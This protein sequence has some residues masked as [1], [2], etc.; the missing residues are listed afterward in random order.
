MDKS[1]L[2]G[3]QKFG[4]GAIIA[5]IALC[6]VMAC[7]AASLFSFNPLA[8]DDDGDD[9]EVVSV[10]TEED[11]VSDTDYQLGNV[12]AAAAIDRN[13]C[14]TSLTNNFNRTEDVYVV[15]EDSEIEAGTDIFVR[16][17]EGDQAVEDTDEITAD[18]DYNNVC[19]NFVFEPEQAFDP[20]TYEAEVYVNGI[21]VENVQFNIQ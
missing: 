11:I 15:I 13:G 14:A 18:Q 8:G 21:P 17:Y 9:D 1:A 19:V 20:G 6:A 10:P 2:G 5:V 4:F 7:L 12:V 3:L 16:L